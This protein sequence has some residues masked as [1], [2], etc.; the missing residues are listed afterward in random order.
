[1]VRRYPQR[2]P[3]S[4]PFGDNNGATAKVHCGYFRVAIMPL[5]TTSVRKLRIGIDAHALGSNLGGN[6][7]YLRC[8]LLGLRDHPEHDYVLYLCHPEAVE[9]AKDLLPEAACTLVSNSPLKRLGWDLPLATFRDGLDLMHLQYV[10]PLISG[11]P[12][13][14]LIH[15]LSYEHH[16]E[17]FTRGEVARFRSTIPRSAKVSR[18]VMTVSEF[19][20]QDILHRLRLSPE[21]VIVTPNA[22]PP[23]FIPPAH[24]ETDLVKKKY[25]IPDR[26]LLALGNLQP[27]KNLVTLLRAWKRIMNQPSMIGSDLVITGKRAWLYEAILKEAALGADI[28]NRVRFTGYLPQED[29]P[30][31]YSGAQLFIYPSL[32]EGFGLPPVEAMACGTPV[33]VGRHSALEEV[34]GV[35]ATYTDITDSGAIAETILSL[36]SDEK[37]CSSFSAA[38]ILHARSFT[39][40]KL[41]GPTVRAWEDISLQTR[42]PTTRQ[43]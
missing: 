37:S 3:I 35:A 39:L 33:V 17:W 34:C 10:S 25:G 13:S 9:L 43:S 30:A 40:E 28:S 31:L 22:L 23:D 19:C 5:D 8:L 21:K 36:V 1:M 11:C 41:A 20:R 29:L 12:I 32:F 14:L 42:Q 15:D 38:G 26:Y 24:A 6:E 4:T 27:R 2:P 7:T 16:P 18:V